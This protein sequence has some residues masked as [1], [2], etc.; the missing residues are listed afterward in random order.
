MALQVLGDDPRPAPGLI[1]PR[2]KERADLDAVGAR[3]LKDLHEGVEPTLRL[4]GAILLATVRSDDKTATAPDQGIESQVLDVRAVGQH[5]PAVAFAVDAH[6]LRDV[7][8]ETLPGA[9]PF[10][11]LGLED[12]V[13]GLNVEQVQDRGK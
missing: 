1:R 4:L 10:V 5:E 7:E 8:P 2:A 12:P 6:R 3:L 9:P 11:M 13:A